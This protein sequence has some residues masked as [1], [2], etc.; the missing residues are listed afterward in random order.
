MKE[1]FVV[2]TAL[3]FVFALSYTCLIAQDSEAMTEEAVGEHSGVKMEQGKVEKDEDRMESESWDDDEDDDKDEDDDEDE[4]ILEN[5]EHFRRLFDKLFGEIERQREEIHALREEVG[6]LREML[7]RQRGFS[8]GRMVPCYLYMWN[9][10]QMM[11]RDEPRPRFREE[12]E[13]RPEWDM[14]I[15]K[16]REKMEQHPGD[17]ELHMRLGQMY[18]EIGKMEAAVEQYKAALEIDPAFDP[19]Y[20]ALERI[21]K[22][23]PDTLREWIEGEK[24]R[25]RDRDRERE[26]RLEDSAG[27]VISSNEAEIRLRIREDDEAKFKVPNRQ[28]DDGSWVLNNDIS[29]FAKSLKPGDKVKIMWMEAEGQRFIHRIEKMR[30]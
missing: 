8:E 25:D 11:E 22:R 2:I 13:R 6:A 29:E 3:I 9:P 30:E 4:E 26:E 28:K 19:T 21:T 16:L 14:E 24:E 10:E 7:E 27:E 23:H 12:E 1:V 18:E 17:I 15:E 20:E 5:L